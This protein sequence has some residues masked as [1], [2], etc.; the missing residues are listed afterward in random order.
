MTFQRSSKKAGGKATTLDVSD[1]E[2]FCETC[3]GI[4]LC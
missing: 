2:T 1:M 4:S 3:A